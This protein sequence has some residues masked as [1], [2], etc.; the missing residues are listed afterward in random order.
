MG[1]DIFVGGNSSINRYIK[2]LLS[3][4]AQ[5]RH[6]LEDKKT[7]LNRRSAV[8]TDLDSKLSSLNSL[9]ERLTDPLT[10]YFAAKTTSTSD[11]DLITATAGSTALAG[12]HDVTITRLASADT[13][14]SKQYTKTAT[15]LNTFFNTNGSQTFQIDVAHP[16]TADSTNRETISVTI[17]SSGATNDDVLDDIVLAVNEAMSVAVTAGTI[18]ADEKTTASVVH[19]TDGT[20][21]LIFKSGQSGYTYR[22]TFTDSGNS[23]L[24]TLEIS[25]NVL[26]S[27]TS[28]GY[29]TAIGT[30]ASDSSLNSQL[31]VDGLTFYRDSNSITDILDGV[32]LNIL[33]TTASTE[34]VQVT[35]DTAAV[36]KEIDDILSSYNDVIK[37]IREKINTDPDTYNRGVL[38]GDSQYRNLRSTLRSIMTG[39]VTSANSGNPNY[40]FEI[41]I[42]AASDG[43]LSI[44]D[45]EEFED[46]LLA[47]S[48]AIADLFNSANGVATQLKTELDTFIKV[49]GLIKDGKDSVANRIKNID[50]H[51]KRFDERAARRELQLRTEFAKMQQ[52]SVLLGGQ[53]AA[54]QSFISSIGI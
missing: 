32:T 47:S 25:N 54:F 53:F 38:A 24:S 10:N 31:Q 49:G 48:S 18:D 20:S 27:G 16:T 8:L 35:G 37:Y 30:S 40:L 23:L 9:A 7:V 39:Q 15:D 2:T 12:N 36:K 6:D 41:G 3:L 5:P 4:E 34:T 45:S 14:V 19:E 11:A 50:G 51:I 46:A 17:N 43:T 13:R 52:M 42:T 29:I 28:G 33:N 1:S 26:S 44:S 22:Q 21:R